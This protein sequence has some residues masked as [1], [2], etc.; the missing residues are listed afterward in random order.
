[1]QEQLKKIQEE[2]SEIISS[3]TSLE[4]LQEI[5]RLYL[6]KKGELTSVLKGLAKLTVE[7]KKL[8]GSLANS[9]KEDLQNKIK[10]KEAELEASKPLLKNKIDISLP[11]LKPHRGHLHPTIQRMYDLNDAFRSWNC[12]IYDGNLSSNEAEAVGQ[13]KFA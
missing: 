13:L 8:I 9:I 6:G 7:E 4:K 1:M 2:A 10:D 12:E 11:P 3:I 5:H